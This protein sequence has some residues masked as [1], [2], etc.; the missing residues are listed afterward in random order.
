V[1]IQNYVAPLSLEDGVR[2]PIKPRHN[3]SV[4]FWVVL[5]FFDPVAF[6]LV[7]QVGNG[8]CLCIGYDSW[9]RCL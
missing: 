3:I 7:W 5:H 1:I 8:Y 4:I 2:Y 6:G 9:P